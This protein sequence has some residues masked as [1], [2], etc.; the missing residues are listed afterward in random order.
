MDFLRLRAAVLM[1]VLASGALAEVPTYDDYQLQAR[2]NFVNAF[3]L[4]DGN[5]F[6]NITVQV[7]DYAEV[8]FNITAMTGSLEKA[9]WFGKRAT[10]QVEFTSINDASVGNVSLNNNGRVVFEQ[11]FVPTP[12]L[13]FYDAPTDTSGL[14]TTMPFGT[15][16]WTA[17]MV[18]DADEIGFRANF[19]GRQAF[20]SYDGVSTTATHA[21]EA[22]LDPQSPFSFLFTPSF[23]NARQIAGKVRVGAA[24]QIGNSQPDEIRVF[25]ADSSSVLIAEDTDGDLQSQFTTFDNSVALTD[26]GWVAFNAGLPGGSRGVFLSNGVTVVEIATEDHPMVSDLEFFGPAV[27]NQRVV[28]FRAFDQN[29]LRAIFAGDGKTLRKVVTEHDILPS[30]LGPARVDQESASSPVFGGGITINTCGDVA[31]NAGLAPPDNNQIEWGSGVYLAVATRSATGDY[32]CDGDV[33]RRD[34]KEFDECRTDPDSTVDPIC[35]VFDFDNDG[36]ADFAD[37]AQLQLSFNIA[38]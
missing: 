11:S 30:D 5:L 9:I 13:Y 31:F 29:G 35:A 22:S 8:A 36:D 32:D 21:A 34:V 27:N 6:A 12:G 19:A 2:A 38:D 14:E 3:N 26:D 24:G 37:F 7:N 20:V 23:N 10:G 17:A 4:P 16:F 33:D 15:T 18:N 25:N 1:L 28:A